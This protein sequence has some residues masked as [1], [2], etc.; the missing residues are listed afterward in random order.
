MC[1][2]IY[3]YIER[4]RDIHVDTYKYMCIM[5]RSGRKVNA[6]IISQ[7]NKPIHQV[8]VSKLP[9]ARNPSLRR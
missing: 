1:M 9:Q 6:D 7:C 2:C 4:E 5:K 8:L 3:I